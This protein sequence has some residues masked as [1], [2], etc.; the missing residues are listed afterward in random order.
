[1]A[2]RFHVMGTNENSA[3]A[4]GIAI[5]FR[6][7]PCRN[8]RKGLLDE[9]EHAEVDRRLYEGLGNTVQAEVLP[10]YEP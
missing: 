3:S 2:S 7:N 1:M 8:E 9:M 4:P 5:F 10:L 6:P